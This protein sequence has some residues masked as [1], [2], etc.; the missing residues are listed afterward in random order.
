MN[1][2]N[3]SEDLKAWVTSFVAKEIAKAEL[4]IE[5]KM[6]GKTADAAT[7]VENDCEERLKLLAGTPAEDPDFVRRE[8][9]GLLPG[10]KNITVVQTGDKTLFLKPPK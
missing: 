7:A 4:R 3:L 1:I 8:C 2:A 6:A 10:G 5:M 9:S